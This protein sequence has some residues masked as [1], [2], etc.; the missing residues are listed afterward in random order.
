[1]VLKIDKLEFII[2][3]STVRVPI[4]SSEEVKT[5]NFVNKSRSEF[6]TKRTSSNFYE[7]SDFN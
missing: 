2:E 5:Q 6:T 3:G 1:M 4:F 7:L